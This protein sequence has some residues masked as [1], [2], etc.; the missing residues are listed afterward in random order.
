MYYLLGS[1]LLLFVSVYLSYCSD[2]FNLLYYDLIYFN[3]PFVFVIS[4]QYDMV[5]KQHNWVCGL[6]LQ[7][8]ASV[9]V[10][11]IDV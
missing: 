2:V 10:P 4:R 1:I 5:N 8:D 9:V 6:S 3:I 7:Y 11:T